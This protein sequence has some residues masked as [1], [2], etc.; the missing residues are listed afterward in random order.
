MRARAL[1][2]VFACVRARVL[3]RVHVRVRVCDLDNIQNNLVI[4]SDKIITWVV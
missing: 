4:R 3:V 1:V 2:R